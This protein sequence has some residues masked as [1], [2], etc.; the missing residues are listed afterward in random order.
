VQTMDASFV[1][2]FSREM[3]GGMAAGLTVRITRP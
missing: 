1:V 2:A 3:D